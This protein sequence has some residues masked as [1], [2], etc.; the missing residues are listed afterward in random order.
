MSESVQAL[1]AAIKTGDAVGTEQAFA[2]AIA[3]KLSGKLDDMRANIAASMFNQ[4]VV[5]EEE[6]EL[7][8]ATLPG[9]H[10]AAMIA[11]KVAGASKG[12]KVSSFGGEHF[13]HH[14]EDDN[15]YASIKHS[16]GQFHVSSEDGSAGAGGTTSFDKAEDAHKHLHS[17]V[18]GSN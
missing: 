9:G 4:P 10:Q 5:A 8:E 11:H 1:V 6:T 12:L 7:D 17:L 2:A 3:E 16:G 15:R 18:H 14:P 13:V